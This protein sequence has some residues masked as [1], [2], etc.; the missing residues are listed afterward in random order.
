MPSPKTQD[1]GFARNNPI[2]RSYPT[3]PEFVTRLC[4]T[5]EIMG[6]TSRNV[7][8]SRLSAELTNLQLMVWQ[9]CQDATEAYPDPDP[10]PPSSAKPKS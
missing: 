6:R 10:T 4:D 7:S 8:L 1:F 5:L 3:D 9:Y 2:A